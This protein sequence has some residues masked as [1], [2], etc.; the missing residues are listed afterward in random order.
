MFVNWADLPSVQHVNQDH[1]LAHWLRYSADKTYSYDV[2]VSQSF[3]GGESWASLGDLTSRVDRAE[4]PIMGQYPTRETLPL[5][6]FEAR[7]RA[8]FGKPL[9]LHVEE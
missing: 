1:W 9:P 4:L 3:D 7:V 8:L 2:V 6:H 5:E